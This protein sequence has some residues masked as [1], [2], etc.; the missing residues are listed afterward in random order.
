MLT[1]WIQAT[2]AME[3]ALGVNG[4]VHLG[5]GVKKGLHETAT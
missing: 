5:D 4:A 3:D 1:A 2:P